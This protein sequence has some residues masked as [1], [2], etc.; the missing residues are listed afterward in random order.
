MDAK[1]IVATMVEYSFS[2]SNLS[3]SRWYR[4]CNERCASVNTLIAAGIIAK[5]TIK[6]VIPNGLYDEAQPLLRTEKSLNVGKLGQIS[7]RYSLLRGHQTRCKVLIM[8]DQ[9]VE[10]ILH[11]SSKLGSRLSRGERKFAN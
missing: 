9:L 4:D 10:N 7:A 5:C 3:S 11:S 6:W 1:V 8:Q 2:W